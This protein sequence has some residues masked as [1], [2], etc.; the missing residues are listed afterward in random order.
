MH[1]TLCSFFSINLI[2]DYKWR[3]YYIFVFLFLFVRV[4]VC[5]FCW[6]TL[7]LFSGSSACGVQLV[8]TKTGGRGATVQPGD[9]TNDDAAAAGG[10]SKNGGARPQGRRR[11]GIP[12]RAPFGS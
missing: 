5:V 8:D 2:Y 7:N 3:E 4:I 12:Q 9:A 1:F 10:S 11:K 6:V